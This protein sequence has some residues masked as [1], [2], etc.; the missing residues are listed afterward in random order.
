MSETVA[1]ARRSVAETNE[2]L[3][4]RQPMAPSWADEFELRDHEDSS[5]DTDQVA[6]KRPK[7]DTNLP[8]R[9]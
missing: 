6:R 8:R 7:G 9:R 5:D 4:E 3:A 2:F 1:L